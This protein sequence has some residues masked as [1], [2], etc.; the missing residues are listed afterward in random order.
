M[1]VYCTVA[2]NHTWDNAPAEGMLV[3]WCRKCNQYTAYSCASQWT[4]S[5]IVVVQQVSHY[6]DLTVFDLD[7]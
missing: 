6:N 5:N 3:C 1:Y 2:V 7:I 4:V